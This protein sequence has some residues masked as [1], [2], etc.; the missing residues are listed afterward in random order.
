MRNFFADITSV[1]IKFCTMLRVFSVKLV[2][3]TPFK[4]DSMADL[5]PYI[6][7]LH[8]PRCN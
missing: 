7:Q 5:T 3:L 6:L 1:I 2:I 8:A 4:E